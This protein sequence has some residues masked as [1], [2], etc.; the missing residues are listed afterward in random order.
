MRHD[1]MHRADRVVQ[2]EPVIYRDEA[3]ANALYCL[4]EAEK[5][6]HLDREK[7]M[8]MWSRAW[9]AYAAV[10]PVRPAHDVTLEDRVG[11][12]PA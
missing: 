2:S 9:S 5:M 7:R 4:L 3:V 10:A 8:L 11:Q 1:G 12:R 6:A